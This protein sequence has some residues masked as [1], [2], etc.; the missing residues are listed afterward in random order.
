MALLALSGCGSSSTATPAATRLEREDFVAVAN[1]LSAAAPSV[2]RE[3]AATRAA[4]PLIASGLPASVTAQQRARIRSAAARAAALPLAPLLSEARAAALTGPASGTGGLFRTFQGLSAHGWQLIDAAI[5]TGEAG[6][7]AAA[8][9][10]RRNVGLYIESVYDAHFALAQLG[11][12]LTAG[13][14]QLGGP[15][16]FGRSLTAAQMQ[17]LAA[18]YSEA[19]DRLHPHDAV[20]F[21]S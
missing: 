9:F 17:R 3:V 14:T 11:K 4:W 21:G 16:A 20:R 1:A 8:S 5:A 10:A 12:Q 6:T 2:A 19:S 7:P 18:T 13:Y 15:A